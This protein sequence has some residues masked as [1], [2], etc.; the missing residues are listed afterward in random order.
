MDIN[1]LDLSSMYWEDYD[2]Q[3]SADFNYVGYIDLSG[4]QRVDVVQSNLIAQVAEILRVNGK[5]TEVRVYR[6][7]AHRPS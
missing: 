6:D 2:D 3:D 7:D 5:S 1:S 4:R